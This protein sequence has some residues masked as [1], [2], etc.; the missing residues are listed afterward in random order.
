MSVLLILPN[1]LYEDVNNYK[2]YKQIY[3]IEEPIFFYDKDYRPI[4]PSKIKIAYLRA[5][6]KCYF[7]KLKKMKLKVEYIEYNDIV[8]NKYSFIDNVNVDIYDPTDHAILQK[9]KHYKI[10]CNILKTPNFIIDIN[11]LSSTNKLINRHKTF[12]ELVKKKLKILVNVNNKDKSNRNPPDNKLIQDAKK[13]NNKKVIKSVLDKYYNEAC[14]YTFDNFSEHIYVDNNKLTLKNNLK[15][16]PIDSVNSYKKFRQFLQTKLKTFGKYQDS[17]VDNGVVLHHSCISAM[18]NIGLL[19]P[20]KVVKLVMGYKSKVP[21][22]S[23]EGYVRQL[24]G[25][26][27]YMRYLYMFHYELMIK[28]NIP[29][30]IKN[31]P[32][33][34]Y[35]NFDLSIF[36]KELQKSLSTGY[37]HHIIRLMLFLNFFILNEI[38]PIDIYK[39]FMTVISIDAYDWVMVSNI[40]AM[41]FFYNKAMTRPYLC[42]SIYITKMSNYKPDGKWNVKLD[43]LYKSFIKNKPSEYTFYYKHKI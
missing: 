32:K 20:H 41:G 11:E 9:L 16:Y 2:K 26:R 3:L 13:E 29:N 43:D 14:D 31:M 38:N 30:N 25:W 39:W 23:L 27:E 17:I 10:I 19:N 1:Q 4:K 15:K 22:N 40:F 35:S 36:D 37:S 5:C 33:E 18:M 28:S 21:M 42:S 12:Y 6:M 34:W 7:D 8:K 24:I